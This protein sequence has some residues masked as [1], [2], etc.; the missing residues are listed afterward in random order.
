M[1]AKKN[2]IFSQYQRVSSKAGDISQI[3]K[4]KA[5]RKSTILDLF[6]R[7]RGNGSTIDMEVV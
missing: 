6:L 5:N 4:K 3:V 2:T 1:K 7:L